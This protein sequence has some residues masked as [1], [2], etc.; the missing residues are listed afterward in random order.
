MTTQVVLITDNHNIVPAHQYLQGA[1]RFAHE[2][3]LSWNVRPLIN[4]SEDDLSELN[5]DAVILYALSSR[6]D[7]ALQQRDRPTVAI[8]RHRR[9]TPLRPPHAQS[10]TP[11]HNRPDD[12]RS[13]GSLRDRARLFQQALSE[14]IRDGAQRVPL[15]TLSC[16]LMRRRLGRRSG[17][18]RRNFLLWKPCS[19]CCLRCRREGS[20][21]IYQR[22]SGLSHRGI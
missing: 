6:L 18:A 2:R 10:R 21:S 19:S 16:T 4:P 13:R 17:S 5:A 7:H 3:E 15:I 9:K 12:C 1:R 8:F 11:A 22:I 20:R 14:G